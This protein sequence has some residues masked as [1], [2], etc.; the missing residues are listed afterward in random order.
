MIEPDTAAEIVKNSRRRHVVIYLTEVSDN[1][2]A[3][4]GEL[5]DYIAEMEFGEDYTGE[6]RKRVYVA[7]YQAHL[8]KMDDAGVIVYN[9]DRGEIRTGAYI[10]P[11]RNTID[12]L[13][14]AYIEA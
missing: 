7:L 6:E 14:E 3:T 12:H 13:R 5:A 8:D 2:R 10:F 1:A 4:I 9:K 11:V